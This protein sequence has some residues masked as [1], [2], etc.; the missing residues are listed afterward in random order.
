MSDLDISSLNLN[1]LP[2]LAL[3]LETRNV[4]H[5]ARRAGVSQSAMS[6]SLS[7]LREQ[8]GDELLVQNGRSFAL[9]PRAGALAKELPAALAHVR[10][11]LQGEAPFD[12][13]RSE[14]TFR[15]AS[16]DYFEFTQL[17]ALLAAS[18]ERAPR[19]SFDVQRYGRSTIE[20][21][22]EGAVDLAL[23]GAGQRPTNAALCVRSL[24]SD[25]FVVIARRAHP[26][27]RGRLSVDQFASS[28]H[29][30]VSLESKS[31]GV[32]DVALAAL[33]RARRIAVRVENFVSAAL[34]VAESDLLC[35][36]PSSV[37]K[38]AAAMLDLQ[39]L[40]PPIALMAPKFIALWPRSQERDAAHQWLRAMV[41]SLQPTSTERASARPSSPPSRRPRS[42]K[43]Q[44][45]RTRRRA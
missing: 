42:T 40:A 30:L 12:P 21:L 18:G 45:P 23:I 39:V 41:F 2:S 22:I 5:A 19:V 26:A 16:F 10:R 43:P 34:A 44:T 14:R 36:L 24:G 4:T 17:P 13:A 1:L 15:I 28:G 27:I 33:G 31:H 37:A 20:Q 32:V 7:A 6:H 38:R 29:V 3:L 8:L 9:T 11:A 35:T 25:P